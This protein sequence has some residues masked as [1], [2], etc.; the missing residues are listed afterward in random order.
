M[1]TYLLLLAF[2]TAVT[3]AVVLILSWRLKPISPLARQLRFQEQVWVHAYGRE[4]TKGPAASVMSK[5]QHLLMRLAAHRGLG[6]VVESRLTRA[7]LQLAPDKAILYNLLIS[8]SGYLVVAYVTASIPIGVLGLLVGAVLPIAIVGAMSGRRAARLE[9]QLPEALTLIAGSL[10][11]GYSFPQAMDMVSQ[12]MKPPI[13][14]DF[15]QVI[16]ETRLGMSLDDGLSRLAERT[17]SSALSWMIM[18]IRIQ[19]DVGGNLAEIFEVLAVTMHEREGVHRQVKVLTAEGRLSAIILMVMPFLLG[20]SLWALN[21]DYIGL[22]VTTNMGWAMVGGAVFLMIIGGIWLN[23]I[24][25][26]EV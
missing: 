18:A 17:S 3:F 24:V 25:K 8:L 2:M 19:H 4:A 6:E 21:P 13:A 16:S 1:T 10:K 9:K 15:R 22:L 7:G 20:L 14:D 5:A 12:E 23:K 11:A 26:I